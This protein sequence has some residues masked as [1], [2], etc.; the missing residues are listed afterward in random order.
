M[1]FERH[2]T[3]Q[4]SDY[5]YCRPLLGRLATPVALLLC[6]HQH[7]QQAPNAPLPPALHTELG[8]HLPELLEQW[9]A[10]VEAQQALSPPE[11]FGQFMAQVRSRITP[12]ARILLSQH[13]AL[14]DDARAMGQL[15][16]LVAALWLLHCVAEAPQRADQALLPR[17][18]CRRFG[19]DPAQLNSTTSSSMQATLLAAALR[20]R[21]RRL[22]RSGSPLGRRL[23]N[24]SGLALRWSILLADW[25]ASGV[26]HRHDPFVPRRVPIWVRLRLLLSA[27]RHGFGRAREGV[28]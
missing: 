20:D 2:A 8:Q 17:D 4:Y 21:A 22:L 6:A 26:G 24:G 19:V 23:R 12:L 7:L 10:L 5:F 9:P 25:R 27:I 11:D 14:R 18:E 28:A 1:S 13:A 3:V 15:D 16:A